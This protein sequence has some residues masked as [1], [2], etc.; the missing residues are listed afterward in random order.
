MRPAPGKYDSSVLPKPSLP[1]LL[2][3]RASAEGVWSRG[4]GTYLTCILASWPL[5]KSSLQGNP[6]FLASVFSKR[7]WPQRI[8][9][10]LLFQRQQR[11]LTASIW[12]QPSVQVQA[13]PLRFVVGTWTAPSFSDYSRTDEQQHI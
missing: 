5:G 1:T 8:Q 10:V 12:K 13:S 4:S 7:P 9:S 11:T 6:V 3:T 2:D